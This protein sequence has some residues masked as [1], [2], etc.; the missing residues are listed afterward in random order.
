MIDQDIWTLKA[1]KKFGGGFIKMLAQAAHHADP[2]NLQ[3]IKNAWPEYWK[4][5][6]E[7]GRSI[8]RSRE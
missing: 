6:E 7:I 5:Y 8:E 4:K 3:K 2:E 1:M